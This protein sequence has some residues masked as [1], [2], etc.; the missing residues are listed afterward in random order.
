MHLNKYIVWR[1]IGEA[2]EKHKRGTPRITCGKHSEQKN[3]WTRIKSH[4]GFAFPVII[5]KKHTMKEGGTPKSTGA[6]PQ[7]Q[8]GIRCNRNT[9]KLYSAAK[10]MS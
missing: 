4:W 7:I 1:E 6:T 2:L 8:R 10:E 5:S 3:S 9:W